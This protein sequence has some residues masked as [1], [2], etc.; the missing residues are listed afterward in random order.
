[1]ATRYWVGGSGN[2]SDAT[3]HWSNASGGSPSASYL[4]TSAD[5]VVFDANSNVGTSAFTVTVDT[6]SAC[7]NFTASG[8]DGAMTVESSVTNVALD[9]YGSMS[10]PAT[11][12][13]WS[14]ASGITLT[15][16]GTSSNTITTN[17]NTL[18]TTSLTLDAVGGTLTLGS[19]LTLN[20]TRSLTITNGTF[21]T[22]ASN[23][24]L[25]CGAISSSNSNVRTISLNASAVTATSATPITFT[26][27]TNLT[28]NAGT[29]TITPNAATT[30]LAGGGVTFYNVSFS[31]ASAGTHS[32]SGA[33]TFN[34]L[35]FTSRSATGVRSIGFSTNQTI[36][37]TLTF[38]TANT[39]IRRL[40]V[41]G[42]TSAGTGVG[43]A[44][45]LTVATLATLA[46]VDF[47]DITAA[48]ASGTWSGTRIGDGGGNSNIT[49][50]A[51]APKYWNLAAGGNWSATAWATASGG[52]VNVNNFPL[53]QDTLII[54]NT[55]L[56][57]S[58]TITIDSG[59]WIPEINASTR[60]NAFTLASG[61]QTPI[62]FG[63]YNIPSVTTVT[64]TGTWYFG[65]VN[66][67][68]N[69]TTNGVSIPFPINCNGSTTNTVKLIDSL[70]STNT[71]T[72][73]QGTLDLN[74]N[75]L[76]CTTFSSSN[77]ITRIIAFGTGN[78]T[79]TGN[80]ATVWSCAT[81]TNFSYTGTPTTNFTYSGS[82]GTRTIQHGSTGGTASNAVNMSI[83]A[84]TDT[85]TLSTTGVVKNLA[86][87]G[88]TG[89]SNLP[90]FIYGD[91]TLGSGMTITAATV[92]GP[93]F[94]ATS[95]TQTVTSNGVTIQRPVTINAPG[96]TISCADALTSTQTLTITN[97]TLQLKAGATSTVG[98]FATSGTNQKYLQSTTPGTQAT[99]SDASG[100]I[101]VS[102]LTIKDSNATGGATWQAY[103]TNSNVNDGNNTGWTF[104]FNIYNSTISESVTSTD[105]QGTNVIN[106]VSVS[107]S[108]NILD[109][110]LSR[111]LWT[112]I[113]NGQTANWQNIT[114]T[115]SV[116]TD[117]NNT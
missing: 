94:A 56:N 51:G 43:T 116:W 85:I 102:Y 42:T 66:S 91:L 24:A 111:Y 67:T 32:I 73:Q 7:L 83:S 99:I 72:F 3:N 52:A 59:W 22:S 34:N 45:T 30:T 62:I 103:T 9:V 49:F 50:T 79:L 100:T 64:G 46:D 38:G 37:N 84:G 53:A 115:T 48:G 6:A 92:T 110:L 57:T 16:R 58:A 36:N 117:V 39:A 61:T 29:S 27:S 109:A 23:Y 8:L 89:S 41:Y 33:N 86:F 96:A 15:F 76:T 21:S 108:M 106:Y 81:I 10:L 1:M 18:N 63:S 87:S 44:I 11:N 112:T 5:S 114:N 107:E 26:T 17:G 90:G 77:S 113:N 78:I 101:S 74:N 97:G 14:P 82:T 68:Q 95:G 47:R 28:F 35:T 65:A 98:M 40:S 105:V 4:P 19:A 55:G 2:W 69:I 75:T 12:M 31:S 71:V 80:A 20:S 60:T 54:E 13:N 25:S 88:F 70:A 93:T 104:Y